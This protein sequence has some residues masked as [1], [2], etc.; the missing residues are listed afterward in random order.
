MGR[1]PPWADGL[2]PVRLY[3]GLLAGARTGTFQEDLA[4][5]TTGCAQ[6]VSYDRT[7][8]DCHW[9]VGSDLAGSSPGREGPQLLRRQAGHVTAGPPDP[10]LR[11]PV[12]ERVRGHDDDP[13][14]RPAPHNERTHAQPRNSS[15]HP[16]GTDPHDQSPTVHTPRQ[17]AAVQE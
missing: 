10:A 15:D 5:T 2:V 9:H 7:L 12:I 4:V 14:H 11:R 13:P 8:F 1:G 6:S 3:I 16:R 17:V